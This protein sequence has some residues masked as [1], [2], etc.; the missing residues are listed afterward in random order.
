MLNSNHETH[1]LGYSFKAGE[2]QRKP[3]GI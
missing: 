3:A 1:A 2:W